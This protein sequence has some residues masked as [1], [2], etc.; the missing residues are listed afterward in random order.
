MHWIE[1]ITA[2][3]ARPVSSELD[4]C[5]YQMVH[6]LASVASTGREQLTM[7]YQVFDVG[8]AH[9]DYETD[10]ARL[11]RAFSLDDVISVVLARIPTYRTDQWRV[12]SDGLPRVEASS[13]AALVREAIISENMF[14][15]GPPMFE[16][17]KG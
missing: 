5:T 10:L 7:M 9:P 15:F 16:G 17:V 11:V 14:E 12:L 4:R 8:T 6:R 3:T 13:R 1:H 2:V